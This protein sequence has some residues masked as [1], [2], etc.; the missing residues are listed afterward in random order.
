MLAVHVSYNLKLLFKLKGAVYFF[1][2][3]IYDLAGGLSSE[4]NW[5]LIANNL[6]HDMQSKIGIT[7]IL[8]VGVFCDGEVGRMD[9]FIS[10]CRMQLTYIIPP[11]F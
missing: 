8:I 10:C 2:L 11:I 7:L 9:V 6:F 4:A 1:L 3:Y 5:H